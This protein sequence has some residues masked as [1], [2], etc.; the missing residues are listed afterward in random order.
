MK[1][2][3]FNHKEIRL[4]KGE[5]IL[6]AD[7]LT[8]LIETKEIIH[9]ATQDAETLLEETKKECEILRE[10]AKEKGFQEGLTAFNEHLLYFDARIKS[11]E[12]EMQKK[13]LPL[14]LSAAKKIVAGELKTRP[15]AI[16]NIVLAAIAPIAQ[17]ARFTIYVHKADKELLEK[18]KER[19]KEILEHV[20]VLKIA[21]RPD[22]EQ[23]GCI[24][25][26]ESGIINATLD[27]QWRALEMAFR[28]FAKQ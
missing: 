24:I 13:V 3:L 14:A 7:T 25:E 16:V 9:T 26:T 15:E 17:N 21:E 6:P 1:L 19:I 23:G 22:I 8:I 11:L 2:A 28:K 10:Q 20:Q 18:E 12:M 5:K 4:A 27:N